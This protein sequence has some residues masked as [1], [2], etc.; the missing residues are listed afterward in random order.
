[1]SVIATIRDEQGTGWWTARDSQGLYL[2]S[3]VSPV[4]AADGA[5]ER[6]HDLIPGQYGIVSEARSRPFR[7][8]GDK[9]S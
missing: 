3:G 6:G 8:G 7:T 5:I 2:S 1:M 9:F 4:A